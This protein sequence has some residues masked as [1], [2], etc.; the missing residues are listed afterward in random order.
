MLKFLLSILDRLFVIAVTLLFTQVPAFIQQYRHQLVGHID[1]L[2]WY[3]RAMRQIAME[4]DKTLEQFIQK[5]LESADRDF[6]RQGELMQAMVERLKLFSESLFALD[7]ASFA[8]RPWVF[9]SHL[10]ADLAQATWGSF[11]FGFSFTYETI[12]F[13]LI[14]FCVAYL[15]SLTSRQL[16]K[17][18]RKT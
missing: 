2:K 17:P 5:F 13:A 8:T 10:D 6:V 4:S 18:C 11:E 7:H 14:G 3:V 12:F 16:W 15:A 9:L 1:E